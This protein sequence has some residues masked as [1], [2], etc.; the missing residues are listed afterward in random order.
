MKYTGVNRYIFLHFN[1]SNFCNENDNNEYEH[2]HGLPENW[3]N[4]GWSC[5]SL[6][7]STCFGNCF[8]LKQA[9]W[10]LADEARTWVVS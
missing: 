10:I 8:L 7:V 2:F 5:L 1:F 9:R 6:V 4:S 3:W